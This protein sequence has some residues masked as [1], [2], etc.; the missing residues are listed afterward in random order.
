MVVAG[1]VSSSALR[2]ASGLSASQSASKNEPD[3][4]GTLVGIYGS[5]ELFMVEY[6]TMLAQRLLAKGDYDCEREIRTLELLKI[7]CG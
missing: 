5:Q 7:R 4:V 2:S 3:I 1:D 6:R